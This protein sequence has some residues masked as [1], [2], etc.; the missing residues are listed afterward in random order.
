MTIFLAANMSGTDK[1]PLLV[2]GKSENP[3]RKYIINHLNINYYY[4]LSAWMNG[5]VSIDYLQ[6]INIELIKQKRSILLFVDNC[7]AHPNLSFSNI[8]ILF[9][10][11]NTTSVLQPMDAGIIKWFKGSY[12]VKLARKLIRLVDSTLTHIRSNEVVFCEAVCMAHAAC[13][14]LNPTTITNCLRH[15]GFY[16]AKCLREEIID[17]YD[18]F[19]LLKSNFEVIIPKDKN[20]DFEQ[21]VDQNL[22]TSELIIIPSSITID[23]DNSNSNNSG[24]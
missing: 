18:E 12:R 21:Y 5:E 13:D 3:R 20:I 22:I 16:R 10:P 9:L 24:F 7:S 11:P 6:K 4:N 19:S 1:L 2:I 17:P 14:E 23:I 15:C 8:K